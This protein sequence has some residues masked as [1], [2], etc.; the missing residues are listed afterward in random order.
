MLDQG[1]SQIDVRGFFMKVPY[2]MKI[3]TEF[4]LSA[5]LRLIKFME[6]KISEF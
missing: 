6:L 3:D 2:R 1:L 5:W 4:N